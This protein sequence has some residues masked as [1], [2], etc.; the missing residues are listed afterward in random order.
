MP[1]AKYEIKRK[2]D[3]CGSVFL[4]KTLTLII[5]VRNALIQP[6]TEDELKKLNGNRWTKL[7]L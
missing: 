5:V 3:E 1:S 2:C 7:Y 4:A 6:I